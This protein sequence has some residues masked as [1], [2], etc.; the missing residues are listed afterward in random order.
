MFARPPIAPPHG[1]PSAP[2]RNA[3]ERAPSGATPPESDVARDSPESY[4]A[5]ARDELG[6]FVLSPADR[7]GYVLPSESAPVRGLL[8]LPSTPY[9]QGDFV[10]AFQVSPD[11]W[12][13]VQ[14]APEPFPNTWQR[15]IML[16]FFLSSIL[17]IPVGLV[18]ARRL[19]A[20]L[21]NFAEAAERLG[22][23]PSGKQ[24]SLNGPAE[25]GRAARAF[26]EMQARLRRYID[27]RTAMVGAISH[28]LPRRA[29]AR[30]SASR[31]ESI[32]PRNFMTAWPTIS[33][34]WRR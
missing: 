6:G 2:S 11:R 1:S 21:A 15:R 24:A 26:N 12:V 23:D 30:D 5:V 14:P 28:D 4:R 19:A 9:L 10:A 18:F 7:G 20:P 22:R 8:G 3:A 25:I 13:T 33:R 17:V 16:W 31:L 29:L 34:K 27:D 32:P